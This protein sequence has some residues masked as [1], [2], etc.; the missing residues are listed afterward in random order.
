M[1][2]DIAICVINNF[3][4]PS[5]RIT[6]IVAAQGIYSKN[7]VIYEIA[8]DI[9]CEANILKLSWLVNNVEILPN[10]ISLAGNAVINDK[11]IFHPSLLPI[12][13]C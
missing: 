11:V 1:P 2:I 12:Y 7:I 8:I 5:L 10:A 13:P 6:D 4:P 3:H 9:F